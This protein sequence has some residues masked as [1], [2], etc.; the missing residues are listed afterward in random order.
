MKNFKNPFIIAELS[1]NH[2]GSLNKAKIIV[3]QKNW[4]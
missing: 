2:N 3:Q 1:G 4:G